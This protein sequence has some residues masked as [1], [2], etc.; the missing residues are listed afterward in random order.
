M[1]IEFLEL[2]LNSRKKKY[3]RN[4]RKRVALYVILCYKPVAATRFRN[5]Q[6]GP[7]PA[8]TKLS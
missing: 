8:L 5:R 1:N 7:L 2:E 4:F 6:E 3:G